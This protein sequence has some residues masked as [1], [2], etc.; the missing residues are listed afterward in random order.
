M[1]TI[2]A[3]M[4]KTVN[5][6][7]V[8]L[9]ISIILLIISNVMTFFTDYVLSYKH[10]IGIGLVGISTILYFKNKK[11]Y[12]YLFGLTLIIGTVNLIDIYY[13]KIIFGIGPIKFNPT[14][15][16]LL[17]IFLTLNKQ[18]LNQ[19]FPEKELIKNDLKRQNTRNAKFDKN[20]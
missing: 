15:L 16:I 18:L 14:F 11:I 4:R 17:I 6:D 3:S 8:P 7:I 1:P 13:F 9:L 19:M 2:V 5:K 12:V 10:Y 20:V